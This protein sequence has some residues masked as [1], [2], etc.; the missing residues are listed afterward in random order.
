MKITEEIANLFKRVRS[1]LGAPVRA[2]EL[3][4]EQLCDLLSF[5]ISDYS[6]RVQNEVIDNN[7]VSFYGKKSADLNAL[8][9]GF[10][11]RSLDYTKNYA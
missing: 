1:A 2:V 5:C 6:E 10:M 4:D 8:M 3:K 11:L 7:W 9:R